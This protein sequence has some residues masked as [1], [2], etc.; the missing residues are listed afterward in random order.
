M[1]ARLFLLL[2]VPC[3][4]LIGLVAV[5]LN[6]STRAYRQAQADSAL[7]RA[8][9]A[10]AE[11]DQELGAEAVVSSQ[12]LHDLHGKHED[13]DHDEVTDAHLRNAWTNSSSAIDSARHFARQRKVDEGAVDR[14][15]LAIQ[16]SLSYRRDV[17][18]ETI[19][20]LQIADRYSQF[21]IEMLDAFAHEAGSEVSAGSNNSILVLLALIRAR[22]AHVDERLILQLAVEYHQWAPGQHSAIIEAIVAQRERLEVASRLQGED[23][24]FLPNEA[25]RGVRARVFLDADVPDISFDDWLQLSDERL[26][27][28]DGLVQQESELILQNMA[29]VEQERYRAL[30]LTIVGVLAALAIAAFVALNTAYR[31]IRRVERITGLAEAVAIDDGHK[32]KSIGDDTN[33]EIGILARA[34]DDMA[35]RISR[36][37]RQQELESGVLEAIAQRASIDETFDASARLLGETSDGSPQYRLEVVGDDEIAVSYQQPGSPDRA[38]NEEEVRVAIGFAR[39]ALQRSQ[40][41]ARLETQATRDDLTG[42]LNRRAI[43]SSV[44]EL[45]ERAGDDESTDL[46]AV[47]FVDLDDFKDVNDRHGHAIGDRT[48]IVQA[49]RLSH[50]ASAGGGEAGRLGGDEFLLAFPSVGGD[51]ELQDKVDQIVAEIS[52]AVEI[53]DLELTMGLSAGAALVR[54]GVST[55][56]LLNE[57]D[58]ALYKAKSSG[59]GI[60]IVSTDDLRAQSV[61]RAELEAAFRRALAT[62]EFQPWFQPIWSTNGDVLSGLEALARWQRP[63]GEMVMPGEF[64]TV[65]ED[66]NLMGALDRVLFRTTCDQVAAWH[67]AGIKAPRVNINVSPIRLEDPNFVAESLAALRESGCRPEDIALEVTETALITDV[68][69]TADRLQQLRDAGIAI[70]VDDFGQ[71]YSSL[72]YLR[73]L[74]VDVLKIDREFISF[75]DSSTTNR[76][77]VAAVSQLAEALA[78]DVVAEGVERDEELD[79]LNSLGCSFVQGYLLG[80]PIPIAEIEALLVANGCAVDRKPEGEQWYAAAPDDAAA[81]NEVVAE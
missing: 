10:I 31:L 14:T 9:V 33:D 44:D 52:K 32:H 26:D 30:V 71:G 37:R 24:S 46:A 80:R 6:S 65:A 61:A 51:A 28:L 60:A 3:L 29:D 18:S 54:K 50:I 55:A 11:V 4:T 40:D 7:V 74:P 16:R 23:R 49:E 59:R 47:V 69:V 42:L 67:Q 2:L 77:I 66:L 17:T 27:Q 8:A 43:L 73:E 20:P 25:L 13:H 41:D 68:E 38:P 15:L 64:L 81:L 48:L 76:A 12:Y 45:S 19:S 35:G 39:M 79:A 21:R 34:F 70:A 56:D 53:D 72:A 58:T 78:L 1:R 5:L 75:I 63:N 22:S 57:A 36:S 62:R